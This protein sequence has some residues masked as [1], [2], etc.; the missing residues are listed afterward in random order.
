MK[1]WTGIFLALAALVAG[2]VVYGWRGVILALS[3]IVFWLL[4]QFSRLMRTM[5]AVSQSPVGRID[6]AVMLQARLKP[7]MTM[8][9]IVELAQSLGRRVEDQPELWRWVDAGGVELDVE[10]AGGQCSRWT[11]RR[12]AEPGQA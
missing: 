7:G 9:Q 12:P 11:L 4:L 5:R 8:A 3:V 10:M 2:G 1:T 6:S